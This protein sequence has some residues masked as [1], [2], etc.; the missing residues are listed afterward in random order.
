MSRHNYTADRPIIKTFL[1]HHAAELPHVSHMTPPLLNELY[2]ALGWAE[3]GAAEAKRKELLIGWMRRNTPGSPERKI[4]AVGL[5]KL[6]GE[7]MVP[8]SGEA[9]DTTPLAVQQTVSAVDMTAS[10][11][12]TTN[13]GLVSKTPTP[14]SVD[15]VLRPRTKE[16]FEMAEVVDSKHDNRSKAWVKKQKYLVKWTDGTE[17]WQAMGDVIPGSEEAVADFHHRNPLKP[18]PDGYSAPAGWTPPTTPTPESE[19][20]LPSPPPSSKT[21]GKKLPST[22]S[23]VIDTSAAL[24]TDGHGHVDVSPLESFAT[25]LQRAYDALKTGGAQEAYAELEV[26]A[27]IVRKLETECVDEEIEVDGGDDGG[28]DLDVDG[29]DDADMYDPE[30]ALSRDGESD[31]EAG[32]ESDGKAD[33]EL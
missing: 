25:V 24:A 33:E 32:E 22:T 8:R 3:R 18:R 11:S 31:F 13:K 27:S 2:D 19:I 17:S 7:S 16:V 28:L 29:G 12:A 9:V 23:I 4:K 14:A 1:A 20:P 30:C 26:A 21:A 6:V 5:K 15:R 10:A